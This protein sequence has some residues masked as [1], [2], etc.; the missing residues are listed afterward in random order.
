MISP[1]IWRDSIITSLVPLCPDRPYIHLESG[2]LQQALRWPCQRRRFPKPQPARRL[3]QTDRI[4]WD[5][6]L[7]FQSAGLLCR[8]YPWR[9]WTPDGETCLDI[10]RLAESIAPAL[11]FGGALPKNP[12]LEWA[13]SKA[14]RQRRCYRM[15]IMKCR[16]G[17]VDLEIVKVVIF[18]IAVGGW[19][20]L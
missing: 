14:S 6:G 3:Q 18:C 16:P 15:V 1:N 9:L 10:W 13:W 11:S 7:P 4:L 12:Q 2:F 19:H 17:L 8:H 5:W 20:V